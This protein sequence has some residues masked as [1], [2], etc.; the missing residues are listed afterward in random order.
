[1]S[2]TKSSLALYGGQ[3]AILDSFPARKAFGESEEKAVL[4]VLDFYR[5]KGED[6]C[7]RGPFEQQ[8]CSSFSDYMGGGYTVAVATGTASVYVALAALELPKGSEVIISPV[9]DAGPLSAIIMQQMVPVV[10]D[11]EPNSFNT[12]WHQIEK[13]ITDKTSCIMLVHCA[14]LPTDVD[15]I[16]RE[17]KKRGIKVLEDCAQAPGASLHG[18]LVGSYGDIMATSTMYRKNI[19]APGSGGLIFCKDEALYHNVLAHSDRGK[20][21]WSQDYIERDPSQHLFPALNWNTNDFSCAVALSSLKR[22]P[23]TIAKRNAFME[24]IQA[25]LNAESQVCRI[26]P[27]QGTPSV[28][29]IQV[30]VDVEKI[31]QRKHEYCQALIAEGVPMNPHYK[32]L[33][34]D[35]EWSHEY[36][37]TPTETPNATSARDR[38]F[39]LYVNENYDESHVSAIV[40]AILK[41]DQYFTTLTS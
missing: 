19:A 7:Y 41:V 18:E 1:M 35:W 39:N 21:L 11:S 17:A 36:F 31:G 24:A 16:A 20:P 25:R 15:V 13:K 23:H 9:T 34:S 28:F 33:I 10:A 12:S 32:F 6:P 5:D 30:L 37:K 29:Y 14:G 27:W 22:L 4:D 40:T 8:L 26:A 38:S 3:P 2:T